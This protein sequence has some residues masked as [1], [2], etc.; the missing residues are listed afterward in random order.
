MGENDHFS[1]HPLALLGTAD[2]PFLPPFRGS[3]F[4]S[5]T[6]L[7]GA[8]RWSA[9]SLWLVRENKLPLFKSLSPDGRSVF[10]D[11]GR[12]PL[13]QPHCTNLHHPAPLVTFDFSP[14]PVAI[15]CFFPWGKCRPPQAQPSVSGRPGTSFS[16]FF[17]IEP[18]FS[19]PRGDREFPYCQVPVPFIRSSLSFPDSTSPP[20]PPSSCASAEHRL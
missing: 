14:P 9:I 12:T 8:I 20:P 13:G 11:A 18:P 19:S 15:C 2:L 6:I 3:S 17:W 1:P 10:L 4:F 7:A 5:Q 16:L